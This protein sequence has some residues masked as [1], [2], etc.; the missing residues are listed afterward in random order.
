MPL[1]VAARRHRTVSA[2]TKTPRARTAAKA[3]A[4]RGTH[5][6]AAAAHAAAESS[7]ATANRGVAVKSSSAPVEAAT[8]AMRST[9]ATVPA[10]LS[11]GELWRASKSDAGNE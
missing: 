3:P 1:T 10:M 2:V 11:K 7:P 5:A 8:T 4:G 6:P 9:S